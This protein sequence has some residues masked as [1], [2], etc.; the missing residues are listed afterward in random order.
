MADDQQRTIEYMALSELLTR[1]H[2]QNPKGHDLGAIIQSYKIH[3][4]VELGTI[5]DRTGLFLAGHG[6][7]E[8]LAMMKK[9]RLSPPE[10]IRNGGSDW[11]VPVITGYESKNDTQALAYLAA[12]N[13]LTIAGGWDE[14]MLAEML[15]ELA[16][17]DALEASGFDGDELD[18]LLRD[19]DPA[20]HVQFTEY[21]ESIADTVE[22]NEC[23]NCGHKYPK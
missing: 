13:K 23:P 9:Q 17:N 14:V 21:D 2:P 20:N 5:D 8:A 1:L 11:F 22:Y 16:N 4:Y 7:T 15:Q 10:Y 3:G 19:L 6:R 18:D 12:S